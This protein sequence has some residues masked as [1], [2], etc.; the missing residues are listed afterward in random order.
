[1]AL[2]ARAMAQGALWLMSP[3]RDPV[4]SRRGR[5]VSR[6]G[7]VTSDEGPMRELPFCKK[8][9]YTISL[10]FSV[11]NCIYFKGAFHFPLRPYQTF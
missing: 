8:T 10:I 9:L 4:P 5:H 7:G 11:Y 1:M 3:P 6:Q 2:L